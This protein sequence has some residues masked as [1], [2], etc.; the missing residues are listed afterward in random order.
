ME[1]N[2]EIFN[3]FM[4]GERKGQAAFPPLVLSRGFEGVRKSGRERPRVLT[5]AVVRWGS[6]EKE[7]F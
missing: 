7:D 6:L 5:S 4:G 3:F 2:T 1:R